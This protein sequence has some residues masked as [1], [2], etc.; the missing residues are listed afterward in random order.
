[1]AEEREVMLAL[2]GG[3]GVDVGALEEEPAAVACGV[4]ELPPQPDDP[5]R[6]GVVHPHQPRIAIEVRQL[7]IG[8]RQSTATNRRTVFTDPHFNWF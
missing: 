3:R 1:M 2:Q 5:H 4:A 6:P 7:P 8:P